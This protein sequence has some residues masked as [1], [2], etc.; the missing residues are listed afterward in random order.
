L[1]LAISNRLIAAERNA[2]SQALAEKDQALSLSEAQR[3]LAYY[4]DAVKNNIEPAESMDIDDF[5]RQVNELL[6]WAASVPASSLTRGSVNTRASIGHRRRDLAF[7][8]RHAGRLEMAELTF[9]QA[10]RTFEE[11]R[12]H[13]PGTAGHWHY[14]ADT[15][16]EVG[17]VQVNLDKTKE[18][19]QEFRRAID[20][21]E[22][23]VARFPDEHI[24]DA[25]W[26]LAYFDLARLLVKT[27]RMQEALPLVTRGV[28]VNPSNDGRAAETQIQLKFGSLLRQAHDFDRAVELFSKAIAVDPNLAAAWLA[29][30]ECRA[31]MGQLDL[32]ADDFATAVKLGPDRWEA[33]AGRA[34]ASFQRKQW[35]A[36]IADYSR[37]ID[38]APKIHSNWYHRGLARMELGEWDN[39]VADLTKVVEGWPTESDGW[40]LRC[41]AFAQTGHPDRAIADLRQAVAKGYS[42]V[43]Q[44]KSEPKLAPLR[45]RTDFIDLLALLEVQEKQR[46]S[47]RP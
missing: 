36:A 24:S 37:A 17:L 12:N 42:A 33:W 47:Q 15:H 8:L 4:M 21:H 31:E 35:E 39:A 18:A 19:E 3:R 6:N 40:Y 41:V 43:G 14:L 32:A 1:G 28:S 16:R 30:G 22:Q 7:L 2:K 34:W 5:G 46:A 23:R 11:L 20:V 26:S 9:M 10:V 45:L 13:D 25:E 44:L 27:G 38:L 29:R